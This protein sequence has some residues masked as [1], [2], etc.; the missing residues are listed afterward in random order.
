M[1][2]WMWTVLK[3]WSPKHSS[4]LCWL[5]GYRAQH[6]HHFRRPPTAP[7]PLRPVVFDG[8][9]QRPRRASG[10]KRL[11][12][13]AAALGGAQRPRRGCGV[14]AEQR[15][16]GG[17]QGEWWPGASI[18]E[19]GARHRVSPTWGAWKRMLGSVITSGMLMNDHNAICHIR[20]QLV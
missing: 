20:H 12:P 4:F 18:R 2:L 15:R 10:K 7:R 6:S 14:V 9:P 13:N 5:T 19:A 1:C 17:R 3:V 11:R 8:S 16:R